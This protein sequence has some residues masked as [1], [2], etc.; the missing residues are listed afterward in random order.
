[1]KGTI[2]KTFERTSGKTGKKYWNVMVQVGE[3]ITSYLTSAKSLTKEGTE[4][5]FNADPPNKPGDS[6]WIRPL[7]QQAFQKTGGR[8]GGNVKAFALSYGKDKVIAMAQAGVYSKDRITMREEMA[9]D[10]AF[11][12]E[13]G[14]PLLED[15]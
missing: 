14:L 8:Q 1:M 6:A 9:Q 2:I 15:K 10:E 3:G 12:F 7:G 5:E 11:F 4:I 13:R